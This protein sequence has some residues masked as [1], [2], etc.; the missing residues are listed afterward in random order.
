MPQKK[1]TDLGRKL[2]AEKKKMNSEVYEQWKAWAFKQNN[3]LTESV[4]YALCVGNHISKDNVR[5][6]ILA[7]KEGKRLNQQFEAELEAELN[8]L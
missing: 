4:W 1:K 3:S 6:A 5:F 2:F 7:L 8:A